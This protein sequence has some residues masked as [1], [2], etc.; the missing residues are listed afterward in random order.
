MMR[1]LSL[2]L[3]RLLGALSSLIFA[4]L[5]AD[6]L[7]GVATRYVMGS[8]AVWSEELA[9]LLLVWLSM[10]GAALAY[11]VRSH[12]GVDTLLITLDPAAARIAAGFGHAVVLLFAAGV[13]TYGGSALFLERWHAGQVLSALPILKAWVY[14]SVPVSGALI[15]LFAVDAL[16]HLDRDWRPAAAGLASPGAVD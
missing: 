12:L 2:R 8:Q 1:L 4:V 7:W 10:L 11:A 9:R 13:M 14:L 5:V 3:A 16:V 6:V 15:A